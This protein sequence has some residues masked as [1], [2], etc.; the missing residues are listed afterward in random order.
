MPQCWWEQVRRSVLAGDWAASLPTGWP[1]L[2]QVSGHNN[3]PPAIGLLSPFLKLKKQRS[4]V[5][6]RTELDAN[7]D[8]ELNFT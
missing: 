6:N 1:V 2:T 3:F 8:A 5:L 7:I 4:I